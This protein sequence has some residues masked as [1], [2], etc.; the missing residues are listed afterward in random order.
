MNIVINLALNN[1]NILPQLSIL[2]D[3][4]NIFSFMKQVEKLILTN[5]T[6]KRKFIF[7][8]SKYIKVLDIE[9]NSL[10]YD[11]NGRSPKLIFIDNSVLKEIILPVIKR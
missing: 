11:E 7:S 1:I 3:E 10:A 4:D 2:F 6:S 5:Y 9:N 8:K